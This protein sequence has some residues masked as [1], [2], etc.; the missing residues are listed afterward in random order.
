[1]ERALSALMGN[2]GQES[3]LERAYT[4]AVEQVDEMDETRASV[5]DAAYEQFSRMGIQRSTMEDVARRAGVSRI[6]VYRRFVT[7]DALV[8]QVVR[9]EFRRYFDRFLDEIKQAETAA[10]RVVLGFV[11]SLRAIRSNPLIGGLSAAEPDLLMAST[12]SDD[13]RTL[14]IVR[15]FVAG[16]LR[17]EQR[18]GNV[19]PD[20]DIDFVAE[21]M[22]RVSGSFLAIPTELIDLD[23]DEQAAALARRFLVPMLDAPPHPMERSQPS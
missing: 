2:S 20:L 21:M 9:R 18:A 16:Q 4:D 15:Q 14:A 6:T 23:D 11:S 13:G 22:V 3:L 8:E 7:K 10:D 12:I 1:M 17:R 19:S 5:L